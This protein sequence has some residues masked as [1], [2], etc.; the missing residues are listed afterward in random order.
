MC[1]RIVY[2]SSHL[3]LCFEVQPNFL[4]M[5]LHRLCF[6]GCKQAQAPAALD[7]GEIPD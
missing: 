3:K 4:S 1:I 2:L 5:N 6:C 7:Y